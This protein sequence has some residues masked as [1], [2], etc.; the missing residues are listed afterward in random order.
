MAF[1]FAKRR[2]GILAPLFALRGARDQ[3]IG[4]LA[5]L[6][7]L[8]DWA[9]RHRLHLIQLLP[10][11]ET[12]DDNSPYNA[13]SSLALDPASL[14]T[15][16]GA[17]PGLDPEAH[18][19][20]L[21]GAAPARLTEGPVRYR[22]LK[23]LKLQLLEAA[24]ANAGTDPALDQFIAAQL[25]WLPDY[26]LFRVLFELHHGNPDWTTWP[27]HHASRAAAEAW[28]QDHPN[29]AALEHRR[30]FFAFVQWVA[31]A[32]WAEVR[33][34][35]AAR[36]V[37]VM[38]DIPFGVSRFSADVWANRGDFDLE[39]SG[40]APPE[41]FF[42]EDKFTAKWGQNWG[43]PLFRWDAMKANGYAWWRRRVAVTARVF[44]LFRIDHVLGFFR[45][46]A[47]PWSPAHNADF[48]DLDHAAA[49][50][51]AGDLPRFL[52]GPD[53]DPHWFAQNR[54][55]GEER[56]RMVLEAAGATGVVAEDLG[57]VPDYVRPSLAAM[58]VPGFKIPLFERDKP[59]LR[60]RDSGA[61]DPV[62]IC[63]L[64][65]HDHLP[66][67]ALW[68]QWTQSVE[69]GRDNGSAAWEC[70]CLLNWIGWNPDHPPR[71]WSPP[72]HHALCRKLLSSGSGLA[73]LQLPDWFGTRHR[74][75]LPGSTADSN[76]S[77]RFPVPIAHWDHDLDL[78]KTTAALEAKIRDT[79][80]G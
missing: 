14:D 57:V 73:I 49:R 40:G 8:I 56:L 54:I 43:I 17:L 12:G 62:S 61:F 66:I 9:A 50:A 19:R 79:G 52:P 41:P 23:A 78:A 68:E 33:A 60:Y 26:T 80:R 65:T 21:A 18:D 70:R 34:H 64:G 58:G 45:I 72:F 2:A 27:A 25:D 51:R 44:D 31:F 7:E 16:P 24:F 75:N 42:T 47:F 74:F 20:I 6:R 69:S 11:N 48:L 63:T 46:F 36:G 28:L 39:W 10:A 76:W 32:Q 4:D 5:A 29:R 59:D 67:R 15:R 77:E 71:E 35:A 55:A 53:D 1:D 38:G 13:I 22:P 3:G 37:V 30:R